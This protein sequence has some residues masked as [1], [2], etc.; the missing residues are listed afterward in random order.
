M[1]KFTIELDEDDLTITIPEVGRVKLSV[2]LSDTVVF[3][4][5]PLDDDVVL[6]VEHLRSVDFKKRTEDGEN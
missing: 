3:Q 6:H 2:V 1:S 5:L 4:R